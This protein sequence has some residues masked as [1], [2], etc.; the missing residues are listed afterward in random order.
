MYIT[1]EN[2][3]ITL[4]FSAIMFLL[5]YFAKSVLKKSLS[6]MRFEENGLV[7]TYAQFKISEQKHVLDWAQ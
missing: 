2:I 5:N 6:L 1:N 7:A 3:L 4:T